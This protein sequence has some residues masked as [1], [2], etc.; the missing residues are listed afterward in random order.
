M[1]S[2]LPAP[3]PIETIRPTYWRS[4]L[5]LRTALTWLFAADALAAI[6][7]VVARLNRVSVIDDFKS[8]S[9]T[10]QDGRNADQFVS[11]ASSLLMLLGIATAAVLI[12]W[13]W[14]SAKNNEMLRK[15]R[16]RFTPGWSIGGWFIPFANLAIP[17][18]IF[19]DL[20]QGADPDTDGY[21]D[22][23]GLRRSGLVSL[24]WTTYLVGNALSFT[25][26]STGTLD[27]VRAA[28]QQI[29]AGAAFT[30]VAAVLAIFVVRS[31]TERQDAARTS[32]RAVTP[33]GWYADPTARFDHRYWNGSAWTLHASRAGETVIDPLS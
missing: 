16:P 20:W 24:W 13:Q 28:D 32:R 3:T 33:A 31:I 30:T 17:V 29:A 23:H 2:N 9:A 11:T 12:V 18:R 7:I 27:H 4:T 10:A 8:F 21:H 26:T 19:Q 22:W 15:I 1:T 25:V 5:G 6:V 14:R